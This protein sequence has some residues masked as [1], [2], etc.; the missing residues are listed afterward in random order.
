M[1]EKQIIGL[2]P[3]EGKQDKQDSVA[4]RKARLL[5]QAEFYR[6]GIVHAKAGI[7]QGARPEAL[8]HSAMDHATWALR[9]R[10][11]GL[12]RPTGINVAT[13]APYALSILGFLRRRRMLKPALG[14]AAALGGVAYYLQQRRAKTVY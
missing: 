5:R 14:L 3:S 10:V 4:E 6:V 13:V 9:Q 7:R 12:L 11:D 8:F 1:E 2:E